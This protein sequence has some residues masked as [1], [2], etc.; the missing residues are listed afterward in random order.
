[1]EKDEEE[2]Y[3]PQRTF[4]SSAPRK[5]RNPDNAILFVLVREVRG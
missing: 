1:M 2:E 5:E 3:E 4:D